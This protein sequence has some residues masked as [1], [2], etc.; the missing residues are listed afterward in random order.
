MINRNKNE[1]IC[2][3]AKLESSINMLMHKKVHYLAYLQNY[4]PCWTLSWFINMEVV[5]LIK[6]KLL[7][8][9]DCF[10]GW[11]VVRTAQTSVLVFTRLY[12]ILVCQNT[13]ILAHFWLCFNLGEDISNS[14]HLDRDRTFSYIRKA[15][16]YKTWLSW[17]GN[18]LWV[19][20]LFGQKQR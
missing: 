15:V 4:I 11:S 9:G 5:I 2:M 16:V 1:V 12:W 7:S 17:L 6:K 13:S 19:P 10:P 14:C 8:H 18:N 3:K 20:P